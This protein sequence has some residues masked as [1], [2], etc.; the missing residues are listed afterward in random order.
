MP[1]SMD[2][3]R[4]VLDPEEPDYT[5]AA[6]LGPEALP[7]LEALVA[8]GDQMLASKATYAAS[9]IGGD[10]AASVVQRAAQSDTAAV[11][12]AAAAAASNL[13]AAASSEVLEGLVGDADPG[14]RKVAR[15]SVPDDASEALTARLEEQPDEPD[16][17]VEPQPLDPS[18]IQGLMPGEQPGGTEMPAEPDGLMPGE[19][20]GDMPG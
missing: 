17:G 1:V 6:A 19:S 20:K 15:A 18:T 16:P 12:V 2:D 9:L 5:A 4:A 7:H 11:R 10:E 8:S 13:D 14:V 3:V